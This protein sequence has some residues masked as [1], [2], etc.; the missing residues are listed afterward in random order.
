MTH[1][2]LC[3]LQTLLASEAEM[4]ICIPTFELSCRYKIVPARNAIALGFSTFLVDTDIV[5]Y[6]HPLPYLDSLNDVE[7]AAGPERCGPWAGDLA[8]LPQ[9]RG[10]FNTGQ[11]YLKSTINVGRFVNDWLMLVMR[12]FAEDYKGLGASEQHSFNTLTESYRNETL[13]QLVHIYLLE[14]RH[15]PHRCHGVCGCDVAPLEHNLCPP[16]I[17]AGWI[18]YHFNCGAGKR[19]PMLDLIN[20]YQSHHRLF[21]DNT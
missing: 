11:V 5:F 6:K 3:E 12:N 7:I 2:E 8:H 10:F 13:V 18:S 9:N 21:A 15:F 17:M 4:V 1:V 14:A 20:R 16:E 19:Q